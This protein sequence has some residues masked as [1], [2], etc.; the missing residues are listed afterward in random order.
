MPG[1][2]SYLLVGGVQE[3]YFS[4]SRIDGGFEHDAQVYCVSHHHNGVLT[5]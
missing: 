4:I 3:Y 1:N 2:V 5:L